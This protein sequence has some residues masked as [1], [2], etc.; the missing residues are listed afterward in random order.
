[1]ALISAVSVTTT[2]TT[3][4]AAAVSSS[5][6]VAQSDIGTDGALLNVINGSG[7]SITFTVSDPGSTPVGNAG[8]ASAQTV[9]A[10]TDKWFR[11]APGHV[12]PATGVATITYSSATTVTYKLIRC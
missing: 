5:D 4:T 6:T 7:A 1:M 2:A 9:A 12:N 8:T 11:L 3:V 10:G